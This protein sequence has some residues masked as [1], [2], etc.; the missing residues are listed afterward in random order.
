MLVVF[1]GN[2]SWSMYN[3]RLNLIKQF[4]KLGY[5]VCIVAPE[6]E[7]TNKII[8]EGIAFVPLKGLQRAGNNPIQDFNLYREYVHIYN[9]LKPTFIFHYT[10]KPNI[11]GT[12]AA[13][14]CKV[15]SISIITGLGNAFSKKSLVYFFSAFL[16][17]FS[18]RFAAEVWFLN[19]SDRAVFVERAII[20]QHKSFI[21]PGEGVDT[22]WYQSASS[23]PETGPITFLLVSRMLYDKGVEVFVEATRLLLQKGYSI[24]AL[25][26]G[27]IDQENPQKIALPTIEAW[28]Q[29][30]LITYLGATNNVKPHLQTAHVVVLPSF[31]KEGVPMVLLEAASMGKP[32]I[33]TDNPGCVDVVEDGKN[34]YLCVRESVEDLAEK[35]EKFIHLVQA[36]KVKMGIFGR[37]KI[38]ES[39]DQKIVMDIYTNKFQQLTAL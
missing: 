28:Q 21:L 7:F 13:K 25:L 15:Q 27:Q 34:G 5:E 24:S 10:I 16:Y 38:L 8:A 32:I 18:S 31:Y 14:W 3:F 22:N 9:R 19:A 6:D 26:L 30:G 35:M 23:Y 11:Y 17:R 37:K 39:F 33:T 29:E 36:E 20:P 1:S 2:T 4:M 12:L